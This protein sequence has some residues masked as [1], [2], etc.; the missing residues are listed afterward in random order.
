MG[1]PWGGVPR[2]GV[3]LWGGLLVGPS[4][5]PV[6]GPSGAPVVL[7]LD[8][9]RRLSPQAPRWL[10]LEAPRRLDSGC[11]RRPIVKIEVGCTSSCAYSL[12][13]GWRHRTSPTFGVVWIWS[14]TGTT[15]IASTSTTRTTNNNTTTTTFEIGRA[16]LS[17]HTYFLL[18]RVRRCRSLACSA[19]R[20]WGWWVATRRRPGGT[21]VPTTALGEFGRGRHKEA[22]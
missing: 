13:G 16:S 22:L 8:A 17:P 12:P 6:A 20:A 21:P 11:A 1:V 14:T 4:G 9:P 19:V 2:C 3:G 7:G 18:W 15:P 5:V 10:G